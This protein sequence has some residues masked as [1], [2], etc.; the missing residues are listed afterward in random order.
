[1]TSPNL[2]ETKLHVPRP[3]HGLVLRPRLIERLSRGVRSKL[4][5]VSAPAGFGKTTLLAEWLA[6]T[7]TSASVAWVSLDDTDNE[8]AAF[9]SYVLTALQRAIPGVG[10]SALDLLRGAGRSDVDAMLRSLLNDLGAVPSEVTLVLDDYHLVVTPEIHRSVEFLVEHLPPQVHLVV[11]TRADPPLPLARLRGRGDLAEIRVADL[12]F[13]A[14]EA[15]AYFNEAMGLHLAQSDVTTLEGRTEGWIAALQLAAL[16]LQGRDDPGGF[17]AGFAGDD[18]Y[19]VDYLVEEVLQRQP[20]HT[21]DFLLTTSILDRLTGPLCDAVSGREGG[22][23]SLE[24]LDRANLF[25][26]PLDDRREWYRYHHLFGDMLRARLL[27]EREADVPSLHLRASEWYETHGQR[28][29][30]IR[31][32]FGGR[33]FTRAA[34]LIELAL[35][36]LRQSRQEGTRRQWIETLPDDVLRARPVLSNEYAGAVLQRG[37]LDGVDRRLADAERWLGANGTLVAQDESGASPVVMDELSRLTLPSRIAVHRAGQA[38]LLGDLPGAVRHAERALALL[39]PADRLA[40]GAATTLLAIARWSSGDLDAAYEGYA[41]GRANLER[42]GLVSDAIGCSLAMA[43]IRLSQGRLS[44]ALRN[45]EHG[46]R[47]ATAGGGPARRGAADM[48]VGIAELLRERDERAAAEEHLHS[49][50]ALGDENGLPQSRY[51]SRVAAA[52]MR[53]TRGDLAGAIELLAEAEHLYVGDFSPNVR[54]IAARRAKLLVAA[55]RVT[56][57]AAWV[58]AATVSMHDSLSY[59]RE[60]E[61]L[62]LARVLLAQASHQSDDSVRREVLCFLDRLIDAADRGGRTAHVIEILLIQAQAH[63][64]TGYAEGAFAALGRALQLAEPEGYVRIFID[65]GPSMAVLLQLAVKRRLAVGYAP[66]LLTAFAKEVGDASPEARRPQALREP[67][68]ERELEV[69]RL[70]ASDLDGPG[71]ARELVVSLNTVRTHTKKIYAKLGVN[72]RREAV[73]RARELD[74]LSRTHHR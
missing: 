37:E 40:E 58:S 31:H 14:G 41:A 38:M 28:A 30:A 48:H 33:E 36:E 60:F 44:D 73:S 15:A 26:V 68:S 8:P 13:T 70:L 32:A 6:S 54:P 45:Y 64:A 42:A 19:V 52:G 17:I 23:A 69:L 61:H 16:S 20:E 56:E 66:R 21:R 22:R 65:E 55:G 43:D 71:I 47:L 12:R 62:T 7:G 18:R 4:M 24:V 46:L 10:A 25:L 3:R 39:D 57:A 63:A 51:R 59:V 49:A 5:L 50:E 72:S 27:D 11:A 2:I 1:M 35:P 34:E 74:L 53:Q 29:D 67:L 9:W